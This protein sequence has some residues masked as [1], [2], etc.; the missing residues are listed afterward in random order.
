MNFVENA[1][2]AASRVFAISCCTVQNIYRKGEEKTMKMIENEENVT[3][4]LSGDNRNHFL[5]SLVCLSNHNFYEN[6]LKDC[7]AP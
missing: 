3:V 2:M 1:G 5:D 7:C 4:P 6:I